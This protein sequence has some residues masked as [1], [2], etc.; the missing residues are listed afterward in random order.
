MAIDDE[1]MMDEIL[2]AQ[3]ISLTR[4]LGFVDQDILERS[5]EAHSLI[6]EIKQELLFEQA[7]L[8]TGEA[9]F[10]DMIST[11]FEERVICPICQKNN[12][13]KVGQNIVCNC[14]IE[15]KTGQDN[16]GLSQIGE[17]LLVATDLHS[18]SC[19][20]AP[21]FSVESD[22]ITSVLSMQCNFCSFMYRIP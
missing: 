12:L 4:E 16:L 15:L 19:N 10:N 5:D 14:G 1:S 2:Q 22:V 3:F 17:S 13:I 7:N 11:Q 18:N 21:L 6:E 20:Q 8:D 9:F